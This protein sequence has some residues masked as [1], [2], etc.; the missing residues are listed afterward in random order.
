MAR[1]KRHYTPGHVWRLTHR[2]HKRAILFK[3]AMD[4]IRLMHWL[5]LAK[6]E[7]D[8]ILLDYIVT[9]NLIY[10]N[11]G[12]NEIPKSLQLLAGRVGLFNIT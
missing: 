12:L 11:L 2:C 8:L 10:D 5:S 1:V 9:S 3:F 6:K 4:R 7:Y